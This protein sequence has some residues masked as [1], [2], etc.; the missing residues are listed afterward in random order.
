MEWELTFRHVALIKTSAEGKTG[1]DS[2]PFPTSPQLVHL[3]RACDRN[4]M[5]QEIEHSCISVVCLA[6]FFFSSASLFSRGGELRLT[7]EPYTMIVACESKFSCAPS[8]VLMYLLTIL[9]HEPSVGFVQNVSHY[10]GKPGISQSQPCSL[11]V[12][13]RLIVSQKGFSLIWGSFRVRV[14]L[15]LLTHFPAA[16]IISPPD[17]WRS[18]CLSQWNTALR[19]KSW[20]RSLISC[21]FRS[22]WF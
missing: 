20:L 22:K 6:A 7:F 8:S 11:E 4:S 12:D 1:L 19:L 10:R 14:W 9:H 3:K 21:M 2:R 13:F 16:P 15:T 5:L 18:T 17:H